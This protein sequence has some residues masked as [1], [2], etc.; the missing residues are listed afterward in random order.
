MRAE[1]VEGI[2]RGLDGKRRHVRVGEVRLAAIVFAS[3]LNAGELPA[4]ADA[5]RSGDPRPLLRLGAERLLWVS[6]EAEPPLPFSEGAGAATMCNDLDTAWDREDPV[7][8]RRE[9]FRQHLA[10]MPQ[11]AFAPLS[12]EAVTRVYPPQICLRWPAPDRFTPAVPRGATAPDVPVL[13]LS[14]DLDSSVPTEIIGGLRA[15]FPDAPL[16]RVAGA[17]HDATGWSDCARGVVARFIRTLDVPPADVCSRPAY[18]GPAVSA[19]PRSVADAAAARSLRGDD[20]TVRERRMVT[21][22]VLTVLDGWLRSYRIP[23]AVARVYGLRGGTARFDYAQFPDH[24]L[25]TLHGLTSTRRV[26]VHGES[27]WAYATN[28]L[29]MDVRIPGQP[30]RAGRLTARG[31]WGFGQPFH[32]FTVTGRFG[33]RSVHVSVPA[34]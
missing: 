6:G 25:L 10:Q 28:G 1:P 3:G 26:E 24:A 32:A 7:P 34:N 14:G 4:A 21:A 16:I 27:T 15:V 19:F 11:A 23:D 29:R 17:Y 12:K 9:K 5:L 33:P 20:S 13:M 30:G 31:T 8:V 22:A 18:V 2:A